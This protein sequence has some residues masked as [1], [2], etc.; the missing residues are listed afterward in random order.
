MF[1]GIGDVA[2]RV[3]INPSSIEVREGDPVEIL[4][5][6]TGRPT[7]VLDWVR[8][9]GTIN[10]NASFRNGVWRL[11]YA[12]KSDAAEYFCVARNNVGEHR[13]GTILYV[14]GAFYKKKNVF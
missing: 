7:P 14:R 11:P 10:H 12:Q 2:P 5:Q 13:E 4:C 9:H 3:T 1:L 8:V 6:A